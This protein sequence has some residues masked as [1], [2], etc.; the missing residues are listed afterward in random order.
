[1]SLRNGVPSPLKFEVYIFILLLVFQTTLYSSAFNFTIVTLC[2]SFS[3]STIKHLRTV[4]FNVF[5]LENVI[6]LARCS[7]AVIR[8]QHESSMKK[9]NQFKTPCSSD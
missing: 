9:K 5:P 1:M 8:V 2:F 4:I 6:I 3:T 7:I